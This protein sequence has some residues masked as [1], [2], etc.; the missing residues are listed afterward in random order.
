MLTILSSIAQE[1]S[2][3]I[4]TN[5]KWAYEKKFRKG[6]VDARRIYGFDVVDG[7]YIVNDE[8]AKVVVRIFTLYLKQYKISDIVK[9]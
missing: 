7:K 9:N 4:S 6:I 5:V 2:R 1:E 8:E 3:S